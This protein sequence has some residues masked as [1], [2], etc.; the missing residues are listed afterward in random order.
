MIRLADIQQ[1]IH[2]KEMLKIPL[3]ITKS[4]DITMDKDIT[5][6][7]NSNNNNNNNAALFTV[8]EEWMVNQTSKPKSYHSS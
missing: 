5:N 6:S 1:V 8:R 2:T 7:S 3:T 4:K